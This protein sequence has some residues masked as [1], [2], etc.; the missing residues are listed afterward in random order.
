[1]HALYHK[2]KVSYRFVDALKLR[3][4]LSNRQEI[5]FYYFDPATDS[6]Y[7]CIGEDSYAVCSGPER[8]SM[9]SWSNPEV[10]YGQ[11][12][13]L[14]P[15]DRLTH[16]PVYF[17]EGVNPFSQFTTYVYYSGHARVVKCRKTLTSYNFEVTVCANV[18]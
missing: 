17:L 9:F 18:T 3:E 6:L 2:V 8:A 12:N 5:Y 7:S 4:V 13:K 15:V 10:S 14:S 1:M 16:G 11:R